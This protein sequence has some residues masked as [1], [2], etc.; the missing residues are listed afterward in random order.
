MMTPTITTIMSA[1]LRNMKPLAGADRFG[2]RP[3]R[4]PRIERVQEPRTGQRKSDPGPQPGNRCA[5]EQ[6]AIRRS[7]NP[8]DREVAHRHLSSRPPTGDVAMSELSV[9][10]SRAL[11]RGPQGHP[12][13]GDEDEAA[14]LAEDLS[15]AGR[16]RV[17]SSQTHTV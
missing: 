3:V 16:D 2:R 5:S 4:R 17:V 15:A 11:D 7:T 10:R 14:A 13:A 12:R 1:T 9:R 8:P 6:T